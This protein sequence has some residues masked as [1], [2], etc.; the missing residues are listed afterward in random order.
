MSKPKI[1]LLPLYLELYDRV[2]PQMRHRIEKFYNAIASELED[3][4][5]DV[6]TTAI[7]RLRSEVEAAVKSFEDADAD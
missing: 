2:L 1:G 6:L 7:C 5:L 3:R 4:G